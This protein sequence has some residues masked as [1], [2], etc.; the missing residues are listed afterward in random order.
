MSKS[1]LGK[2]IQR[3]D[4][5]TKIQGTRKFPQ[6]FNRPGQ[7]YAAV[8]WSEYPHARVVR[9]DTSAAEAM[10]GVVRILTYKDVP[11]NE[12]GINEIDQPVL[13]AEGE[14]VRWMGDRIA[15]VV[16]ETERIARAAVREVH[17]EYE[18]LPVVTDPREA[19]KEDSLLV[20]EEKGSNVLQ[21]VR[22][23]KGDVAAAFAQAD[24]V[25]EDVYTT[26]CVE[27][28][29]LQPDAAIG[30]IDSQDRVTVISAAQWPHDDRHQMAHML[31]LPEDQIRELVPA[32]GGA[33]GGRE[34]MFIQHLA[35][36]C[37]YV[38]RKPVKIVFTRDE[39]T[40]FTG[41]RHPFYFHYKYGATKEGK[42]IAVEIEAISD[43]GAYASTS[44]PVLS[45]A[46]SFMA[47][48][49]IVPNVKIDGYTVYTNNAIAM[50][51]RGFGATQPPVAYEQQMDRLAEALG[52][53][54]VEFRLKN[55]LETG[56]ETILGNQ[57]PPGTAIKETLLQ[58]ALAAG[59]QER[60]GHW[61]QPDLGAASAPYKR[62]GIGVACA[63]KN[64]CYSFGFDDTSTCDAELILDET[65]A[66][67]RVTLA[68]GAVEVG[69]GIH[70]VLQQIAA[71]TLG[72]SPSQVRVNLVDTSNVPDAGSAS[73][74]RHTFASGNAALGACQLLQS[75]YHQIL[76]EETGEQQVQASYTFRAR[77]TRLTTPYD[78]ETG[79]CN[80][81]VSYSL[82]TQIALVEVDIETGQVELLKMWASNNLGRVVNPKMVFGQVAGAIHMGVGY[83]LMEDFIQKEGRARSRRFSEYF[84]P[85]IQDMPAELINIDV[86]VPDPKGP[87]GAT[88]IGETPTLPTAPAILNA[89]ANAIGERINHLPASPERVWWAIHRP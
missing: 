19:M 18:P 63:Y 80:P 65:G 24:V 49:Y 11:V 2:S 30:Y 32:V 9:I 10:T 54:P 23:R 85:C 79:Q 50:A 60:E 88:G 16:A 4:I 14:K 45:N 29:Y 75:K 62:R 26:H 74:S 83:A 76:R 56:S 71:E 8:V 22:V 13:V 51:M 67:A 31:D 1:A 89:I 46:V 36:L 86:E 69:Q 87:Y 21:H 73:A 72:I 52:M 78:P 35:A 68:I 81:H 25:V 41:K 12:Y 39:T 82:G 66:I 55:L 43:S 27:H 53:D 38:V 77:E 70:T 57:M 59:W 48:P 7:L 58:A 33:F 42:L 15:I 84:I 61:F 20:H 40:Q 6:D 44:I 64:V 37:A 5:R 3:I 28:A 34:D 17:V 47:G